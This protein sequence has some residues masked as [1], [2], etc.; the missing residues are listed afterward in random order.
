VTSAMKRAGFKFD[1]LD[2]DATSQP[3]EETEEFLRTH[4]YDVVAMG[5]IVTGYKHVKLFSQVIRAAFPGTVIIAGNTVA[6]SITQIL[7]TK[8]EVDIAVIGEGENTIVE[9][10]ETLTNS[11]NLNNI[12]G[13]CYKENGNITKNKPRE[14]IKDIDEIPSP[15]WEIFDIEF[16]INEMS[17][18]VNEP[19]PPIPRDEI[20]VLPINTARGCPYKCTFCYHTF[21]AKKYRWRSGET[22]VDEMRHYHELHGIN[23]FVFN[24]ELTF[25]SIKQTEEFADAMLASE[26]PV[27]FDADCRSDL[28]SKDEHVEVA[29]KLKRGG[30]MSLS[31]S[32]ESADS[33]ILN[34]MNKKLTPENYARQVSILDQAGLASLTSIVIG[35]PNETE[36]T[37][38][39]TIDVCIENNIYPSAGY[40]CPQPGTPMY[41]Y[42]IEK[43]YIKDEEA[44]LLAIGD[45]QDLYLN[46]TQMSD[47]ELVTIT[48][49][50]M[51]RCSRELNLGLSGGSLLKTGHYRSPKKRKQKTEEKIENAK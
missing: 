15:D 5:C 16:Y 46:M 38:K 12:D 23:Y 27:Y 36:Q 50:E 44:Y 43:G 7:L 6:Q 18:A 49:R 45:R 9:L 37:I 39:A 42:A 25:F 19:L 1:L 22:I 40:L 33:D 29:H 30:C 3:P 26:L 4:S 35:Y 2:L 48:E 10:L 11:K 51:A 14:V 20:R 21:I 47:K 31:Y 8:T 34:W 24:D 28:F 41:D 17:V 32:L 13:I